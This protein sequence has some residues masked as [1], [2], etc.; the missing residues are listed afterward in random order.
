MLYNLNCKFKYSY[1]I[2]AY[3]YLQISSTSTCHANKTKRKRKRK[4]SKNVREEGVYEVISNNVN[5]D[6]VENNLIDALA[7]RRDYCLT[8]M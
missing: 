6:D 5:F 7:H 4:K 1:E 8:E 3:I 2:T